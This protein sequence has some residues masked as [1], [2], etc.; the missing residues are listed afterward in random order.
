M[1]GRPHSGRRQIPSPAPQSHV[2]P[3]RQER[4]PMLAQAVSQSCAHDVE[5]VPCL[6]VCVQGVS[7]ADHRGIKA[8]PTSTIPLC[9]SE[10]PPQIMVWHPLRRMPPH[11]SSRFVRH[12]SSSDCSGLQLRE[13][14]DWDGAGRNSPTNPPCGLRLGAWMRGP[15]RAAACCSH[16]R[17]PLAALAALAALADSVF[18]LILR[19]NETWVRCSPKTIRTD[20]CSSHV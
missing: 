15:M 11:D 13:R 10:V 7:H 19:E 12:A 20:E 6:L 14:R 8:L 2:L 1:T 4:D 16:A 9:T 3:P 18:T 5:I 17:L